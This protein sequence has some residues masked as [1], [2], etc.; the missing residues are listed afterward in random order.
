MDV[1]IAN[2]QRDADLVATMR[3]AWAR[4]SGATAD[5]MDDDFVDL[6]RDWWI[7]DK[8]TVFLAGEFSLTGGGAAG[9]ATLHEYRRMPMPG[10]AP[11]AWGYLG[12]LFVL[13]A[14]RGEGHDRA[15]IEAV[16]HAA[17]DRGYRRLVLS[18]SAESIPLYRRTGFR[19]AD[20]L[21]VWEPS[22]AATS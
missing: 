20:E 3:Y 2:P 9:M 5:P 10:A 18:P 4:T 6:V 21:M 7:R 14:A 11:S 12:H 22:P 19:A 8:R 17:R 15:L 13:P 1:W 16:Q